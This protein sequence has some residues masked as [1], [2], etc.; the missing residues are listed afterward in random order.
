MICILT[1]NKPWVSDAVTLLE[2]QDHEVEVTNCSKPNNRAEANNAMNAFQ[3]QCSVDMCV[4]FRVHYPP[5]PSFDGLIAIS[6]DLPT[7]EEFEE[8]KNEVI[9]SISSE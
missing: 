6:G 2:S 5:D 7:N 9:G 3:Q 8:V 1:E 4:W